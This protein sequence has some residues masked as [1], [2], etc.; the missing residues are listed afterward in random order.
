MRG[1]RFLILVTA[2]A[3]AASALLPGVASAVPAANYVALGDSYASGAG[4]GDYG[5][6]GTCERSAH[7]YPSL[8][9][10]N[11]SVASF[12]FVACGG[13]TTA[14]VLNNQVSALSASTT[15]VT[16][17]IGGNDVGFGDVM[18][19]CVTGTDATCIDKVHQA[20][21]DAQ[22]RLPELLDTVYNTIR[23]RAPNASVVVLGYPHIFAHGCWWFSNAKGDAIDEGSDQLDSVIAARAG[24][25]GFTFVDV[26][27]NFAGHEVCTAQPWIYGVTV[28]PSPGDSFHPTV[29]GYANAY[30]PALAAVTG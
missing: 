27:G 1:L 9:A 15:F 4:G 21:S 17:T 2:V 26:R 10:D 13:A 19:T 11:H 18:I 3:A 28:T 6:S 22:S 14:D 12:S 16:I 7:G 8:W 29:D 30:Y 25:A 20:E 23:T 24:A 5:T